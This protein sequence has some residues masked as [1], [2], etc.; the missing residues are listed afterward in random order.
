[1]DLGII[2]YNTASKFDQR[3]GLECERRQPGAYYYPGQS[4]WDERHPRSRSEHHFPGE[5][6]GPGWQPQAG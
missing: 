2:F 3:V 1:M 4:Q 6:L 5:L